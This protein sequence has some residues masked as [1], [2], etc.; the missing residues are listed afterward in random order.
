MT[1]KK[2]SIWK[3]LSVTSIS[4]VVLM[5]GFWLVEVQGYV[6]QE[7]VSNM[8][9]RESPYTVDRELVRA[10]LNDVRINIKNN[11]Q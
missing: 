7:Q 6:D 8:I 4:C 3:T 9:Q 11:K 1:D 5:T 10:T 2:D